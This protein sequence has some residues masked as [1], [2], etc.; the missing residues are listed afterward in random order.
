MGFDHLDRAFRRREIVPEC[1]DCGKTG[2]KVETR[3]PGDDDEVILCIT[4]YCTREID[5]GVE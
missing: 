4:C 2:R 3:Y 1:A 5:K